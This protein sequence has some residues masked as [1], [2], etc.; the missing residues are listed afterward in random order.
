MK[1]LPPFFQLEKYQISPTDVTRM[2]FGCD[3][4][5]IHPDVILLP[6]WKAQVF[7]RWVERITVI[8]PDILSEVVFQGRPISIIRSGIG[9]PQAGD[10]VLALGCTGCRRILFAGSIGGLRP[11]MQI[12]DLLLP[13]FTVAGDGF[14]RYLEAQMPLPD[15]FLEHCAPDADLQQ[16]VA[17]VAAP[18]AQAAGVAI[19]SGP[20]YATDSILA[21]FGKLDYIAQNLGCIGIEMETAAVFKAARSVDIRAAALFSVS[22]VPVR[23]K[24]LY[25]GRSAEEK[26]H[27][28]ETRAQVL[29]RALLECL[30]A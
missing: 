23:Q 20:V 29:A 2:V 3:P 24:T 14:C 8:T 12:G 4:Q 22:D 6:W 21:Q 7:E 30:R 18:L 13:E 25:A 1:P 16:A 19:H 26:Q 5:A 9:A 28:L 17:R 10:A 15:C 11:E 27:R